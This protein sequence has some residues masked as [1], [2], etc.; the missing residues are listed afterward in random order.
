[1][2]QFLKK[3]TLQSDKN[4]M[5]AFNLGT[6]FGP[7]LMWQSTNVQAISD[8]AASG[9]VISFLIRHIQ[10]FQFHEYPSLIY[11]SSLPDQQ[12]KKRERGRNRSS[13]MQESTNAVPEMKKFSKNT[14]SGLL[15][16]LQLGTPANEG[17]LLKHVMSTEPTRSDSSILGK[18]HVQIS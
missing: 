9:E 12:K 1:L 3:V 8:Y 11:L 4:K 18:R 10:E 13:T 16:E 6:V 5:E 14:S 7:T 17:S 15:P 2:F